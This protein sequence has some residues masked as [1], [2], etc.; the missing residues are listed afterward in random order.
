M[1]LIIRIAVCFFGY[2]VYLCDMFQQNVIRYIH[3]KD[4]FAKNDKIVVALSGG[5]DSVALLRVLLAGGYAC[6]AVHCNFHLRGNESDRDEAFV[7]ALCSKLHVPLRVKDFD[8]ES[9]AE[10]HR[11]SIEMAARDLR[12]A[13]FEEIR[14]QERAQV[15]GVAHHRDDSVETFLLNLIRGTGIQGLKGIAPK[16]G[17]IVRPLLDESRTDI[18]AYLASLRQDFVTDSTNLKDEFTRNKLR[19]NLIPMMKE[20]NP[21]VCGT[22]AETARRLSEVDAVYRKAM[23]EACSRVKD[24]EGRILI[25]RLRKETAPQ[26]VLFELLHPLG[27][28][29]SQLRDIFRSLGA[30]S[31]RMFYSSDYVVLRDRNCLIVKKREEEI[32]AWVLHREIKE[33]K[34]GFHV[35]YDVH[36]ACLDA[37]KVTGPLTLRKWQA[38]DKFIPF[39][40]RGFKKVRDYL[41]DRKFS[42]FDKENQYVVCSGEDIIWLVNERIDNR[43]RVTGDTR[44]VM[45]LWV[46]KGDLQD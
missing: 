5:A 3:E 36:I 41:R 18:L 45:L 38:G 31:G 26:A 46:E 11:I 39:G 24:K 8:T 21:S 23:Q 34:D 15:I 37:S 25:T 7:R 44:K 42:R 1:S 32:P 22:I 33:I 29:A 28:N 19:L 35:P 20:I 16:N 10:T 12:Y 9:Y 6:V 30:E 40:M 2:N 4:L 43:F 27:F 17:R 14:R 13:W